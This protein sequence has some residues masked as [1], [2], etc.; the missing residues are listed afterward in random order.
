MW[1]MYTLNVLYIYIQCAVCFDIS[2]FFFL[3]ANL[4]QC[5]ETVVVFVSNGIGCIS[6][7]LGLQNVFIILEKTP[8]CRFFSS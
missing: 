8:K 7:I 1:C 6:V 4:A 5:T 2:F 3:L